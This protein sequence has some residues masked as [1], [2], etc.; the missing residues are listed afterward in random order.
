MKLDKE[1]NPTTNLHLHIDVNKMFAFEDELCSC[2]L[3]I[4]VRVFIT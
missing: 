4:N 1:S 3:E 2:Q